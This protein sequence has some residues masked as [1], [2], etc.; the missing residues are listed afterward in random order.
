MVGNAKGQSRRCC[1]SAFRTQSSAACVAF[2][3]LTLRMG[4]RSTWTWINP[5]C[6]LNQVDEEYTGAELLL[7]CPDL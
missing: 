5:V 1:S 7:W 6:R 3:H 4:P 2:T